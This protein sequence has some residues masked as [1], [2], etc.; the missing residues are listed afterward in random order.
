MLG[1]MPDMIRCRPAT[2]TDDIHPA[3]FCPIF[4]KMS[5]LFGLLVI[6]THGIGETGVGICGGETSGH[7]TKL[8]DMRP[9]FLRAEGAIEPDAQWPCMHHRNIK[10][11]QGLT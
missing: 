6:F 8:F 10:S 11:F 1:D 4:D 2:T 7:L 9:H 5:G 3:L